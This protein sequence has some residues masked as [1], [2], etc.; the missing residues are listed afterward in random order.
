MRGTFS[1]GIIAA[2]IMFIGVT[3][4]ANGA[5]WKLVEVEKTLGK[6]QSNNYTYIDVRSIKK[7]ASGK[8]RYWT[9]LLSGS[10]EPNKEELTKQ[11]HNYYT[12]M[13]CLKKRYRS[14]TDE[15]EAPP[16][17]S[18]PIRWMNIQPDSLEEKAL[19][20]VCRGK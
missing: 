13:D 19:K 6:V 15:Y 12:E 10:D 2:I 18:Y 11:G 7:V 16:G 20:I 4:N 5:E 1:A 9:K 3:S 8:V 14:I 17:Y